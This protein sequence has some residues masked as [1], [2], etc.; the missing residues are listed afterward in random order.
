MAAD[1]VTIAGAG[2]AGLLAANML[3]RHKP[4]VVELQPSIPNN[5]SAVLRFRT[6]VVGETLGIPFKQVAMIKT[7]LP[8][9]NPVAD[10][11]AYS[12]KNTGTRRSDR[13]ITADP[14]YEA[15]W[16]APPDLINRMAEQSP[17]ITFGTACDF[18]GPGPFISTMPM[19]ALMKTLSYPTPDDINFASQQA[20]N[21][22]AVIKDTD[23][24]VSLLVP[25]PA[26]PFSRVSITGN[27]LTV[28]CPG[29]DTTDL[30][31]AQIALAA[32]QA[33]GIP[34]R[35]LTEITAH[36]SRYAKILPIDEEQR[37]Q[38][39]NWATDQHD[40]YSLGRFA[41]W[42]PGLLLDD[43]VKDINLISNWL[44]RKSRYD[45]RKHR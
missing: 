6:P 44:T 7:A 10:A 24:Y 40:V 23:A 21:I 18:T 37:K 8:W 16:I 5:H 19:M 17:N 32:A 1:H 28:E 9:M 3:H 30:A 34:E 33:L 2:L 45:V 41:T 22:K 13:S 39:I 31:A 20:V 36:V 15:R 25:D 35:Q 38:F 12:Y 42:R 26:L 14:V 4:K 11:L 27:E 29:I 43:L